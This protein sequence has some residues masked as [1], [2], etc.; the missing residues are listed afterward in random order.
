MLFISVTHLEYWSKNIRI[1][2]K[3][4][5]LLGCRINH[6]KILS[7]NLGLTGNIHRSLK[8]L[9]MHSKTL[10]VIK[11][12]VNA[13]LVL[14]SEKHDTNGSW[15]AKKVEWNV[16]LWALLHTN[17]GIWLK[18]GYGLKTCVDKEFLTFSIPIPYRKPSRF[19]KHPSIVEENREC[20]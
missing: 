1:Y 20:Q 10:K 3:K 15:S 11:Y 14:Y 6:H 5:H 9:H 13:L 18:G 4:D 7:C 16:H 2:Y 19:H 12:R 8:A 17:I